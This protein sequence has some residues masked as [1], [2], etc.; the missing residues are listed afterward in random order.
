[1]DGHISPKHSSSPTVSHGANTAANPKSTVSTSSSQA[2]VTPSSAS[3]TTSRPS[4]EVNNSAVRIAASEKV[5]ALVKHLGEQGVVQARVSSS[6]LLDNSAQQRLAKVNPSTAAQFTGSTTPAATQGASP[7]PNIS[8]SPLYLIKFVAA[9][10]L[11]T[12]LPLAHSSVT[13]RSTSSPLLQPLLTTISSTALKIGDHVE[14]VLNKQG[15]IIIKPDVSS[16][17]PIIADSIKQALPQQQP[18]HPLLNVGKA[19]GSLPQAVQNTLIS[20]TIQQALQPLS[21]QTYSASQLQSV[22]QIKTALQNSGVLTESQLQQQQGI[23]Q[24]I[25]QTLGQLLLAVQQESGAS[26]HAKSDGLLSK[27]VVDQIIGLWLQ[28]AMTTPSTLKPTADNISQQLATLMQLLGV[29]ISPNAQ[30]DLKK[31]REVIAKQLEQMLKGVQEKIHLNQLRSLGADS[32]LP[33]D[34]SA[35][36]ANKTHP[37]VTEL[38]LRWGEYALPLSISIREQE[39]HSS[40][41][42]NA[43]EHDEKKL[44]RRWQ[45]FMSFDLP[46][47]DQ[48]QEATLLSTGNIPTHTLHSQLTIIDDSVSA[49]L[50]SESAQLC[51]QAKKHLTLLRDTL[52]ANGLQVDELLCIN[53]KPPNQDMSLDY[54]L[55]DITT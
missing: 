38:A 55:I 49:T 35:N 42:Q 15:N 16:V 19:L 21:A 6:Q 7:S 26:T 28:Q 1:M 54:H 11:T 3:T 37:F 53:G 14:L 10:P 2:A 44:T 43:T 29:K 34:T 22:P 17:R 12:E 30:G 47:F 23:T 18:L 25:R 33:D 13:E 39:Q 48:W 5:A 20:S 46:A 36:Y 40:S 52:T 8:N 51:Q 4:G 32:T 9:Q 24:D 45:V 27:T 31:T 41:K 50:W